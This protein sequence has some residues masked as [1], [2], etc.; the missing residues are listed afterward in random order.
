MAH[1]KKPYELF[2]DFMKGYDFAQVHSTSSSNATVEGDLI[3][4]ITLAY[5]ERAGG[6]QRR[7]QIRPEVRNG[8]PVLMLSEQRDE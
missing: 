4:G 1:E 3:A 6:P 2:G 7:L 8:V 5:Q